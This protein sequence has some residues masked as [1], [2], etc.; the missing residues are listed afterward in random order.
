[1]KTLK[2]FVPIILVITSILLSSCFEEL[3]F[4]MAP[5]MTQHISM[6]RH[7]PT[8]N[9]CIENM[10][11]QITGEPRLD[12]RQ[13]DLSFAIRSPDIDVEDHV[14]GVARLRD[15]NG[16][17][18][19]VLSDDGTSAGFRL[20][21]QNIKEAN[22]ALYSA[23]KKLRDPISFPIRNI[24]RYGNHSHPGGMQAQGDIV[25]IAMEGGKA[26]HAAVYFLRINGD[27]IS[28]ISTLDLDGSQG[29]PFQ[30][31]QNRAATVGF[32]QLDNGNFL[33]AVSGKQHGKQGIWFYESDGS[34]IDSLTQWNFIDFYRPTCKRYGEDTDNC[35]IG[36]GGGL[37]LVKDCSGEL[38]LLAMHGTDRNTG[39][40][41]EYLQVFHIIKNDQSVSLI[42][43]TQQK[44]N[45]G[46]FAIDSY[47]FRWAG[48][49]Y[50]SKSGQ[51]AVF[52]TE[53][54]RFLGDNDYVNGH[55]YLGKN[56]VDEKSIMGVYSKPTGE[57]HIGGVYPSGDYNIMKTGFWATNWDQFIPLG[58]GMF[59]AY[60][61][62]TGEVHFDYIDYLGNST[63][64]KTYSWAKIWDE[65]VPLGEGKF[66]VYSKQTGEAH[67]DYVDDRGNWKILQQ[68]TWAKIWD[69]FVPLGAGKFL[70]YS[71]HTGEAHIDYV[72]NE[73][74]W[75]ILKQYSWEK[76]WDEFM[77]VYYPIDASQQ[78]GVSGSGLFLAY[79]KRTGEAHI[80]YVDEYGNWKILQQYTWA[81]IWDE[82][83]PIG[84][85]RFLAYSRQT[86]DVHIDK[87]NRESG[88]VEILKMY[89]WAKT[90]THIFPIRFK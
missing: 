1:M 48:G 89:K 38:F 61:K 12:I 13:K 32:I 59:L 81:R 76:T 74:N 11:D 8:S 73:G 67:I 68:Y 5:S 57:I 39:N 54:R 63:I 31:N 3:G 83:I 4:E 78:L 19:M 60:S 28:Y 62:Q 16:K 22:E 23:D 79:S 20:A 75:S 44:D 40:E 90:W 51:L 25:A 84:G 58:R 85:G 7:T 69:K 21:F 29:E 53:R 27:Q 18:R 64:L 37:N 33:L 56:E 49:T 88:I 36:A 34:E 17:G 50:V 86:G 2:Y 30:Y 43:V 24:E 66:L 46:L 41:Y 47:S 6:S 10:I 52:N 26:D 65:F 14:Q 80:D 42:K 35:F 9:R 72:D 45:L 55:V 70:A 87:I 71:R 82:F 77:P 15:W